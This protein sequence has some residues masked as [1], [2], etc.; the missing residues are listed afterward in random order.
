MPFHI[1][2]RPL[3]LC[4]LAGLL[5]G[6]A[7]AQQDQ[8]AVARRIADVAS[9]ALAEYAEGVVDGE[10]VAAEELSEAKLF[11]ADALRTAED[12]EPEARMA[13]LPYLQRMQTGVEVLAPEAGLRVELAGLRRDLA[14]AVGAPLDPMPS[15]GVRRFCPSELFNFG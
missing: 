10:V 1:S 8:V 2:A 5:A 6:P 13:T 12:L 15:G 11:L 9:I 4:L 14:A 7:V 3:T